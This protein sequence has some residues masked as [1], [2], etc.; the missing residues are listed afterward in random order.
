MKCLIVE[1]NISDFSLC[2]ESEGRAKGTIEKYKRDISKFSKFMNGKPVTPQDALGWREALFLT[3]YAPQT[4]NSMLSALNR[5]FSFMGWQGYKVSHLRVQRKIFREQERELDIFE[6]RRLLDASKKLGKNRLLLLMETIC[7]CGIRV[8]E[9]Q[10]ITVD[11]A[12]SG[13]AVISTKGKIRTILL[14]RKLC[15]K[16]QKYIKKNG[17]K[18]GPIFISKSGRS[19]SRHQIWAEMKAICTYAE[20]CPSKVFPHNLRHLFARTFYKATHDIVQLADVLGHSRL[21]T[22]RIYLISTGFDHA[23]QLEQLGL[24]R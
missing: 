8:S 7:S 6:Y 5:F 2:L 11:A 10:A 18:S 13:R 17:I 23:M 22:T 1:G 14:P 12:Q 9:V 19:L 21:E 3:G 15:Q 16:L 24:V 20:V 4:I